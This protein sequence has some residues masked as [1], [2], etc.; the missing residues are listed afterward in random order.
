MTMLTW[1]IGGSLCRL[2]IARKLVLDSD[3][4]LPRGVSPMPRINLIT[5]PCHEKLGLF[6]NSSS[7]ITLALMH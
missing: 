5:V 6:T 3:A 2:K 1:S 7:S 4:P